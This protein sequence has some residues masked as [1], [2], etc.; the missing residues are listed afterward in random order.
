S[1]WTPSRAK[2]TGSRRAA[3]SFG[4]LAS[5]C[6]GRPSS[7]RCSATLRNARPR[8][9]SAWATTAHSPR[10][11]AARSCCAASSISR[12]PRRSGSLAALPWRENRDGLRTLLGRAVPESAGAIVRP[13]DILASLPFEG[14]PA[15]RA[16]GPL[17]E[18]RRRFER[19]YIAAV[20]RHHGG[21]VPDAAV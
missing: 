1:T 8:R 20:L 3:R 6:R 5:P 18:A 9:S 10:R 12:R 15:I 16:P 14:T 4:S 2:S 13:E 21:R 11:E 7:A 17:R 19:E